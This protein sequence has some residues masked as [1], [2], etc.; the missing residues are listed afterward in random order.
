MEGFQLSYKQYD[1]REH[2][3]T[4]Y[5]KYDALVGPLKSVIKVS[6]DMRGTKKEGGGKERKISRGQ[7]KRSWVKGGVR[8][9]E[10]QEE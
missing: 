2:I 8:G 5:H 1:G 7:K 9:E 4:W 10:K 6:Q 3:H